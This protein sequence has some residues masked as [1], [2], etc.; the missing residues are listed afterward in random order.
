MLSLLLQKLS[1]R[2]NYKGYQSISYS[3]MGPSHKKPANNR[4][5]TRHCGPYSD[6]AKDEIVMSMVTNDR[7]LPPW[8]IAPGKV[9]IFKPVD[10]ELCED[11]GFLGYFEASQ[12][13]SRA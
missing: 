12:G 9:L 2:L 6:A 3:R 13:M 8:K 1:S 7:E 11:V 4:F 5:I 10:S